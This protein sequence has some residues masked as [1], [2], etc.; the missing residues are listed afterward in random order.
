MRGGVIFAYEN[1]AP[2]PQQAERLRELGVKPSKS[3]PPATVER[4]LAADDEDCAPASEESVQL[5]APGNAV[6]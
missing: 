6:L 1:R 4:A 2:A 5:H 3:L